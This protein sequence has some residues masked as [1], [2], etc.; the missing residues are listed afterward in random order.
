MIIKCPKCNTAIVIARS[1]DVGY[2]FKCQSWRLLKNDRGSFI[3][4]LGFYASIAGIIIG[5]TLGILIG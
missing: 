4:L 1:E 5:G 2:C 3:L